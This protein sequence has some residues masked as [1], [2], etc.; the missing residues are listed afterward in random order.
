MCSDSMVRVCQRSSL[1][2]PAK[3]CW[4]GNLPSHKPKRLPN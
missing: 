4:E 3:V 2:R 1:T